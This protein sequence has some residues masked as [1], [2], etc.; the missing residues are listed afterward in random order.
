VAPDPPDVRAG[1]VRFEARNTGE[2]AH[3]LLVVEVPSPSALPSAGDQGVDVS[4]LP[5]GALVGRL[6]PLRP[7]RECAVTFR[8]RAGNYALFCNLVVHRASG[9]ESHYQKGMVAVLNV[10]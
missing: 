10:G 7:G 5:K 6:A 2:Q 3:E 1:R 4:A 8:L 9:P